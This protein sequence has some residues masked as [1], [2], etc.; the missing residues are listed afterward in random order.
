MSIIWF[1]TVNRLSLTVEPLNRAGYL[2]NKNYPVERV[3]DHMAFSYRYCRNNEMEFK[4]NLRG[5]STVVTQNHCMLMLPGE[6]SLTEPLTPCDELYFVFD[7]P[8]RLFGDKK[9]QRDEFNLFIPGKDAICLKY[10]A[11]F[12]ELLT[13]PLTP[14][15]CTQLDCLAQAILTCTFYN[16]NVQVN[17]SPIEKIEG[18]I[19][20]HYSEDINFVELAS[21]FGLSFT[22]FRRL[23]NSRH[24]LPPGATIIELRN[25]HAQELLLNLKLSIGE[26]ASLVGYPDTRYFARFFKRCNNITPGEF[27]QLNILNK[28]SNNTITE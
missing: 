14:A 22:T 15:N 18:Y 19:N 24:K 5:K 7:N 9:P 6:Y 1:D 2:P 27:R 3:F 4:I 28:K 16:E 26:V 21:R 12:K 20:S 25:R 17:Q 13:Y 11:L 23:W 8:E 10:L